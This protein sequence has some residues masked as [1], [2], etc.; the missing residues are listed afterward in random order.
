MKNQLKIITTETLK[1][2]DLIEAAIGNAS[3]PINS[4]Q[5][6]IQALTR[7][8]FTLSQK[9]IAIVAGGES[10]PGQPTIAALIDEAILP[11]ELKIYISTI[12]IAADLDHVS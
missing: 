4:G 1:M 8:A 9:R 5:L 10:D 12:M 11:A 6:S 3:M 7:A 2:I